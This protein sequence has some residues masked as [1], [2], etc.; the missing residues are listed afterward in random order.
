MNNE[1]IWHHISKVKTEL[2]SREYLAK[3]RCKAKQ[4][5]ADLGRFDPAT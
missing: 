5:E 3:I 4:G 1:N 2:I